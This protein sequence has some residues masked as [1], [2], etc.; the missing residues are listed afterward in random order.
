MKHYSLLIS[1]RARSAYFNDY[2]DV[3]RAELQWLIGDEA[4]LH[5]PIGAMDFFDIK[6]GED[7][8]SVLTSL[9]FV[10]GVFERQD[11]RLTPL[12][13]RPAFNLHEDFVFG[14]KFRGKTNETLTQLL[15]NIG[16]MCIDYRSIADVKLLDPMCGRATTLFWAM[17]YGIKSKGIEQ[18]PRALA[19]VRQMIKKWCK[20]H[21]QKHQLTEGFVGA[22]AKK[23]EIGKFLEFSAENTSMRL[24]NGD[25]SDA[26][27]LLNDEKFQLIISD[28]PYGI[29]HHTTHKTRN[30]LAILKAAAS[31][32]SHSLKPGGAMVLAFNRYLPKREDLI[33]VFTTQGLQLLDFS[34]PHRMSESIVRDV[35]VLKKTNDK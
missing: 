26:C 7:L 27:Q 22:K 1:Q 21:R 11:G 33:D 18:D 6:A 9:S 23:K 31:E 14:A 3:A 12:D 2:L 17:R 5:R 30:P 13:K 15:I 32:W 35:V 29:Q 16:L 20:V 28:L 34:A 10:Q 25:T 19:D 8:L 24:I 4:I